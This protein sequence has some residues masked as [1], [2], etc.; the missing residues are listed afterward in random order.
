[1]R[2]FDQV[3]L[4]SYYFSYKKLYNMKQKLCFSHSNILP[5]KVFVSLEKQKN[6]LKTVN[7]RPSK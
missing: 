5:E 2:F 7:I 4:F 1:M 3:L 6:I